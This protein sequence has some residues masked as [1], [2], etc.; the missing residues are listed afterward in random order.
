[1]KSMTQDNTGRFVGLDATV[2]SIK[3]SGKPLALRTQV[4]GLE[5]GYGVVDTRDYGK[6]RISSNAAGTGASMW[7]T[8]TQLG[9]LKKLH[10]SAGAS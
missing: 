7:L 8:P 9:E 3:V 4:V 5:D 10:Q 2:A 1:M 6:I